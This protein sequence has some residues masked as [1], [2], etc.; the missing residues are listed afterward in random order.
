M[1]WMRLASVRPDRNRIRE[2]NPIP[3]RLQQEET[4]LSLGFHDGG[5]LCVVILFLR[6]R[7]RHGRRW[8]S[9]SW[10]RCRAVLKRGSCALSVQANRREPFANRRMT[11]YARTI[12]ETHRARVK[13][14]SLATTNPG[15]R[16]DRLS[17]D[18]II[19][20]IICASLRERGFA[21]R[22]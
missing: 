16:N 20:I 6:R 21:L 12:T 4:I 2:R 15:V 8:S 7:G 1:P 3:V 14:N 11:F 5:A 22:D 17:R 19:I 9:L 13:R 18:V 10:S